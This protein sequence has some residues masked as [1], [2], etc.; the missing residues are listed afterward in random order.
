MSKKIIIGSR[1]LMIE[2]VYPFRYDYGKG[3]EVLRV[4]VLETN[5][6]FDEVKLLENVGTQVVEYYEDNVKQGEYTGYCKDFSCNYVDGKYSIEVTRVSETD[7]KL[8]EIQ[9]VLDYIV[10]Q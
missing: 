6:S 10:M 2:Q 5:H 8:D 4:E 7:R 3:K 9:G 1:E